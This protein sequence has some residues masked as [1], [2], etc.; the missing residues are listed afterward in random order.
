[1]TIPNDIKVNKGG[2]LALASSGKIT[3]AGSVANA[4][5]MFVADTID[6]GSSATAFAGEG[7]FAASTFSLGRDF[8]DARNRTTP[9][10]TFVA[11]PDFLMSSYKSK[12]QNLWWFFQKWQELA[13]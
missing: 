7:I 4:Q 6:T 1:V 12:D 9:A 3:F 10:E 8:N 5:G 11:R 2:F 13:P